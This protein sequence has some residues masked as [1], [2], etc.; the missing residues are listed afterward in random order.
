MQLLLQGIVVLISPYSSLQQK[1]M[2]YIFLRNSYWQKITRYFQ[3]SLNYISGVVTAFETHLQHR[4][5]S[6]LQNHDNCWLN[7]L[8]YVKAHLLSCFLQRNPAFPYVT[9]TIRII[10]MKQDFE[11]PESRK[12]LRASWWK[13]FSVKSATSCPSLLN[14]FWKEC[15]QTKVFQTIPTK[16]CILKKKKRLRGLDQKSNSYT[17]TYNNNN[18]NSEGESGST[19]AQHVMFLFNIKPT[20]TFILCHLFRKQFRM[21]IKQ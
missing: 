6:W 17:H 11:A 18:N 19:Q 16:I 12:F 4:P 20:N 8:L 2:L 3:F 9:L 13:N 1:K 5:V 21:S 10:R 7:K 15:K 14:S